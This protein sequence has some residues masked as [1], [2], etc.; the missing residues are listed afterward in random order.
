VQHVICTGNIGNRETLDWLKTLSSN[1]HVVKGDFDEVQGMAETKS[2]TIG[3]FKIGLVH[4]HQIIPWGDEESLYNY[5]RELGCDI[6]I[7]GHTH[8]SKITTFDGKFFVNPGSATGAY[9][10]LKAYLLTLLVRS[11]VHF[12]I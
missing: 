9:S 7:S 5:Q 12:V 2:L 1:L 3:K 6:L 4:G 8:E 11:D 10:P